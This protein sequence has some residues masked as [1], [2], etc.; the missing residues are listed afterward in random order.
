L[1]T[2]AQFTQPRSERFWNLPT[3]AQLLVSEKFSQKQLKLSVFRCHAGENFGIC[4][5]KQINFCTAA[6][7]K[8]AV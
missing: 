7:R 2:K 5:Q 6:Q 4:Q 8:I 1:R 3:K